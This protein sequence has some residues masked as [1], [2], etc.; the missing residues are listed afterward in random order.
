MIVTR[1]VAYIFLKIFIR[2]N[3][4]ETSYLL[5]YLNN[6]SLIIS[7]SFKL[8]CQ[9]HQSVK[10]CIRYIEYINIHFACNLL[11][12]KLIILI[13]VNLHQ[14]SAAANWFKKRQNI[15]VTFVLCE[16]FHCPRLFLAVKSIPDIFK[17]TQHLLYYM[18][19]QLSI[20]AVLI[21]FNAV[22][23]YNC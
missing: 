16:L 20:R 15:L 12:S 3:Y 14:H 11:V 8:F 6:F 1:G 21:H 23:Y 2:F 18:I 19:T 22:L 10:S 5:R 13:W 17:R 9:N 4:Y 7:G